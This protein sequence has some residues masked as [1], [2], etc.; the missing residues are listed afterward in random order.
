MQ[1]TKLPSGTWKEKKGKI[2]TADKEKMYKLYLKYN[3]NQKVDKKKI[4]P[5]VSIDKTL[6]NNPYDSLSN[7]FERSENKNKFIYTSTKKNVSK[8]DFLILGDNFGKNKAANFYFGKYMAL[9]FVDLI[10]SGSSKKQNQF[11]T[12]VIRYA[13]SNIDNVSTYFWKIY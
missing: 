10:E 11:A 8:N 1:Q 4:A 13:M 6:K 5:T 12:E 3:E 2:S 9:V 7:D